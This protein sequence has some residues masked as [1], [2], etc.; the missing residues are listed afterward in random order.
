MSTLVVQTPCTGLV[1]DQPVTLVGLIRVN[2]YNDFKAIFT[3]IVSADGQ[4]ITGHV[5]NTQGAHGSFAMHKV[6]S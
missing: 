4:D 1:I 6:S 3:G 2:D 5:V